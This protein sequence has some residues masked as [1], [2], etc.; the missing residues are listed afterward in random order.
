MNSKPS[1][2]D[3]GSWFKIQNR[4]GTPFNWSVLINI[5]FLM[6]GVWLCMNYIPNVPVDSDLVT[7]ITVASGIVSD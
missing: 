6:W 4:I 1:N 5:F 7:Q 2:N 3:V